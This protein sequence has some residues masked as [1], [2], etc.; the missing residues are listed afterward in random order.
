MKRG[1]ER[2]RSG[3]EAGG[4]LPF[5]CVFSGVVWGFRGASFCAFCLLVDVVGHGESETG[6]R[7]GRPDTSSFQAS[8]PRAQLVRL[9]SEHDTSLHTNRLPFGTYL[10][11]FQKIIS[12]LIPSDKMIRELY[13]CLV[14][15]TRKQARE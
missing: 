9:P 5:W 7:P 4:V 14:S 8:S 1:G 2:E 12:K 10:K 6:G 15:K 13:F 3:G 11:N